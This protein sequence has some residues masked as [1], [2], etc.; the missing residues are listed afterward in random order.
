MEIERSLVSNRAKPSMNLSAA[1]RAQVEE[2]VNT[3]NKATQIDGRKIKQ[4]MD[5]DDFL[6]LLVTQLKNQDPSAPMEDKQFIAQMAQFSQLEQMNNM[7]VE[8]QKLSA[9]MGSAQAVNVLGKQVE[10]DDKGKL[11][12]GTVSRVTSG[13]YPQVLVNGQYYDYQKVTSVIQE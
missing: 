3:A 11:V 12:T 9:M 5:K 4:Q 10:I 8:F 1:E 6:T 7:T 13:L 2:V